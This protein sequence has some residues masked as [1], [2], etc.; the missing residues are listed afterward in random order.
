MAPN[1]L[2]PKQNRWARRWM[3]VVLVGLLVFIL[4]VA[5]DLIG[6]DRS[7]VIGFVQ[8]GTWSTGLALLLLGAYLAV[9][10]IRN[11]RET[12][13]ISDVGSRLIATGYVMAVA[14][15][16][17]DFIGIGSHPLPTIYFGPVQVI[18]LALG[19]LIS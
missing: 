9:R 4:G 14:A 2:T 1:P 18:G 16:L 8:V 11:G 6:M 13:L 10:V 12:T 5:P 7:P 19:V 3:T 17:A 15:S